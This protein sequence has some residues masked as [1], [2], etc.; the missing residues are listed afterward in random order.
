MDFE[1]AKEEENLEEEE[2]EIEPWD[3]LLAVIVW[4]TLPKFLN[5]C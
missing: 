3:M 5:S 4:N 1:M 2:E